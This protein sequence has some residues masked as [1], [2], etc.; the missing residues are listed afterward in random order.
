MKFTLTASGENKINKIVNALIQKTKE[1][2]KQT[3]DGPV[4]DNVVKHTPD[5]SQEA[6]FLS[7]GISDT[8][9]SWNKVDP[10]R[11][12]IKEGFKTLREG[13]KLQKSIIKD[14]NNI[15][16][17]VIEHTPEFSLS[18]G[19]GWLTKIGK[20]SLKK[21]S[22]TDADAGTET[23][24]SLVWKWENGGTYTVRP[25]DYGSKL[26]KSVP[27]ANGGFD[28]MEKTI[29]PWRM[30]YNGLNDSKAGIIEILKKSLKSKA[31]EFNN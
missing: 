19:F 29:Q 25:R 9:V 31:Q 6:Y 23:W 24:S 20:Q 21:R 2:L 26:L 14:E 28:S 22:T 12:F 4:L 18:V 8:G 5:R 7:S 13:I 1:E 15:V 10:Q 30:Y 16:S 17:G 3:I 27:E 11:G